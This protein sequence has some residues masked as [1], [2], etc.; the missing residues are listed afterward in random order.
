MD[1]YTYIITAMLKGLAHNQTMENVPAVADAEFVPFDL[2]YLG[3]F[4]KE[5]ETVR[6]L[7]GEVRNASDP[8]PA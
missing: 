1:A 4:S 7:G 8:L 3:N 6:T 2:S 5:N